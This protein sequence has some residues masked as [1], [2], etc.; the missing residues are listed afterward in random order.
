MKH[1]WSRIFIPKPCFDCLPCVVFYLF[2]VFLFFLFFIFKRTISSTNFVIQLFASSCTQLTGGVLC[3]TLLGIG[4]GRPCWKAVMRG[5]FTL[6]FLPCLFHVTF[7]YFDLVL[8]KKKVHCSFK[9]SLICKY[10]V[11]IFHNFG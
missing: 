7:V 8:Q 3:V 9:S 2:V 6:W 4:I 10:K 5:K 1:F 11:S